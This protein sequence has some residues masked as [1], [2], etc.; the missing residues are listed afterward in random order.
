MLL[1]APMLL[2]A[3]LLKGLSVTGAYAL[4]LVHAVAG[5]HAVA[6]VLLQC[7]V[8]PAVVGSTLLVSSHHD[9]AA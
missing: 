6:G 9:V 4:V 1:L 7:I 2:Q 8:G 5:T 3:F